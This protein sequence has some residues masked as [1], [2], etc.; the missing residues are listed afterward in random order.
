M[1]MSHGVAYVAVAL[2]LVLMTVF[3]VSPLTSVA[4][5]PLNVGK[6]PMERTERGS[7]AHVH[8]DSIPH[9]IA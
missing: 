4:R 6:S 3:K 1:I 7:L 5:F 9:Q 8:L 2:N